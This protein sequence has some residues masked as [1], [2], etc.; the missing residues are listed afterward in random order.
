MSF[1]RD[2]IAPVDSVGLAIASRSRSGALES[3]T[4]VYQAHK[5]VLLSDSCYP[6]GTDHK[7]LG[8]YRED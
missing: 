4:K 3:M 2:L 1:A 8:H 7:E 6:Q 5:K